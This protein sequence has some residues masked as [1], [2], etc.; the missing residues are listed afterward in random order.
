MAEKSPRWWKE[1]MALVGYGTNRLCHVQWVK[2]GMCLCL[3]FLQEVDSRRPFL[4]SVTSFPW[5]MIA[6]RA[7]EAESIILSD[8]S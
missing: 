5:G 1:R 6:L 7:R 2:R 8:C 4:I 3:G